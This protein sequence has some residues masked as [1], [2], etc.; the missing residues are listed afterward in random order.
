[1][2]AKLSQPLRKGL[3]GDS[4]S[5]KSASGNQEDLDVG[6]IVLGSRS[7]S[8]SGKT[9]LVTSVNEQDYDKHYHSI[10]DAGYIL[11]NDIKEQSLPQL[12]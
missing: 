7:S 5:S 2:G 6:G 3:N 10:E 4:Q 11:P 9:R 8:N 12:Q 1:M